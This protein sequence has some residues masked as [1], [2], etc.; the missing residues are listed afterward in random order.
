MT[1]FFKYKPC[2][3]NEVFVFGSN[4]AGIHG[5]GAARDAFKEW[6]AIW[7]QGV[8]HQGNSY[9]IPTKNEQIQTLPLGTIAMHVYTFLKYAEHQPGLTF[10]VTKVGCGLAG[11]TEADIAP[12]FVGAPENCVLPAGWRRTE[13]VQEAGQ[14]VSPA[15]ASGHEDSGT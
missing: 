5:G 8:G 11:Y 14:P 7:G 9:A 10:L 13:P 3:P 1:A 2:K 4:L 15:V 6:G 12:M